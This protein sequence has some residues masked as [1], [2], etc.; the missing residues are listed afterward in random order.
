MP[1]GRPAPAPS[2]RVRATPAGTSRRTYQ[3]GRPGRD[4]PYRPR[5]EW[6]ARSHVLL[7]VVQ[8][9]VGFQGVARF[10]LP[11]RLNELAQLDGILVA[12]F[13][14]DPRRGVH[15][16]RAGAGDGRSDVLSGQATGDHDSL[17]GW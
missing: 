9:A 3:S 10:G 15:P 12:R 17:A 8:P 11:G 4:P 13:A 7:P 5:W 1:T 2:R 6:W 14:L 16:P